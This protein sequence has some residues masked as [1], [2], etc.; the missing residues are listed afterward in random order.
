MFTKPP[1]V[2]DNVTVSQIYLVFDDLDWFEEYWLGIL[3]N[4][5]QSGFA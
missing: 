2:C 1:L 5:T 4:A 3:Q